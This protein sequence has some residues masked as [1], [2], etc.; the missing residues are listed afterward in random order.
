MPG[1]GPIAA[2]IMATD[3]GN[4]KDYSNNRDYAA[5]IGVVWR[6][7]S[8]VVEENKSVNVAIDIYALY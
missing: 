7:V 1:I 8:T 5:S 4:G 3:I 2:T 6:H